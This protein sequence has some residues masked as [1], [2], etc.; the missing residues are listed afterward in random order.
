MKAFRSSLLVKKFPGNQKQIMNLVTRDHD[1]FELAVD[2]EICALHLRH[3]LHLEEID[4]VALDE[5]K[6]I[7]DALELE[8]S[9]FLMKTRASN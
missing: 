8:I 5:Y 6:Q 9:E 1:F 7:K 4:E 3:L 2:Y